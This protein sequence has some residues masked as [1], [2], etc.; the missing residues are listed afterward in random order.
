MKRLAIMLTVAACV[1]FAGSQAKAQH[2]HGHHGHHGYHHGGGLSFYGGFG[3]YGYGYGY[4]YGG[5]GY[6]RGYAYPTY[7]APV[8]VP[9]VAPYY[10]YPSYGGFYYNYPSYGYGL[11][12]W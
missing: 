3:G 1:M 10:A 4:P 11:G 8:I 7:A 6:Y 9:P 5:Y 2:H 12:V